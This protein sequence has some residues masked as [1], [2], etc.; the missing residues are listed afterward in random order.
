MQYVVCNACTATVTCNPVVFLLD[1]QTT[2]RL[3]RKEIVWQHKCRCR[4]PFAFEPCRAT[5][6]SPHAQESAV[7]SGW[8]WRTHHVDKHTRSN[9]SVMLLLL[10]HYSNEGFHLMMLTLFVLF[11]TL[12]LF[13]LLRRLR[14]ISQALCCNNENKMQLKN[15]ILTK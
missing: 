11:G 6:S 15:H 9:A 8:H 14:R 1:L 2:I 3:E 10:L 5:L 12:F 13:S 7:I 4:Q